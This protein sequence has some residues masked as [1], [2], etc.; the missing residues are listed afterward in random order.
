V[1]IRLTAQGQALRG[2]L[3]HVS[4]EIRRCLSVSPGAARALL[5]ELHAYTDAV[6]ASNAAASS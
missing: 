4:G 6:D 5:T 2:E 3:A 1:S